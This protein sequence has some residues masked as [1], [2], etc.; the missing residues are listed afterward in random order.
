MRVQLIQNSV[1]SEPEE[2]DI[3]HFP[4][5]LGRHTEC[6][7]RIFHPMISRKHCEFTEAGGKVV[8]HDL[9]SLNGT[10]LN[11]R[12]VKEEVV[13]DGDEINLGCLRYRVSCSNN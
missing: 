13:K 10:Y 11:G 6:D 7:Y 2:I 5:L 12:R 1:A 3:D 9:H 4:F 8:V